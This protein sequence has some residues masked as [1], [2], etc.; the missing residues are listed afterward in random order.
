MQHPDETPA[1]IARAT[2]MSEKQV[3]YY[4]QMA[5]YYGMRERKKNYPPTRKPV[6]SKG[7]VFEP[8]QSTSK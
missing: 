1:Q 5:L 8:N 7:T 6:A 4:L 3:N 2:G